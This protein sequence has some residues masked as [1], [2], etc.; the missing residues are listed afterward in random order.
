MN[1]P[2]GPRFGL[3]DVLMFVAVVMW[4]VN[5][6]L[7]KIALREMTP[8]G[9]NGWRILFSAVCLLLLLAASGE[10][11]R[12]KRREFWAL[13]AI[14]FAGNTAYQAIFI[15]GVHGTSASNTSLI[16]STSPIFVALLSVVLRL[17]KVHWAA[18]LGIGVSFSG[19][20][21]IISRQHGVVRPA[22]GALRGDMLVLLGTFLWAI[23]TVL[24]KPFLETMSPLKFSALT[25]AFGAFFYI[26]LTLKG[27]LAVS[28]AAVSWNAR[29]A[30]VLSGL[31]G[32][33]FGYL[34]WYFSVQRVGNARTAAYNYLTPIFTALFAAILLGE[35]LRPVQAVGAAIILV[36]VWLT[37]SGYRVFVRAGGRA[38][39]A[40]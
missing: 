1:K 18:W 35:A 6:S 29:L 14:G 34:I 26:P 31:F 3:S 12:L 11:F 32:L 16:L 28:P 30:L 39:A 4:G 2:N 20:F 25:M 37:R 36:G 10:G 5:F 22:G 21:L 9:F 7:V 33:V 13:L 24:A 27:M 38:G 40:D 15:H 23:Y 17:E 19:L 8:D